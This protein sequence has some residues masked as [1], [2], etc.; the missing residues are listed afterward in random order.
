MVKR[1]GDTTPEPVGGRAAERLRMFV[2]ARR[3]KTDPKKRKRSGKGPTKLLP[4][5]KGRV[6]K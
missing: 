1:R 5:H 2:D 3:P 4:G 6:V